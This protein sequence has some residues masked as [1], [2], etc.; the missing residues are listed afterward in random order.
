MSCVPGCLCFNDVGVDLEQP[1][2]VCVCGH[3]LAVHKPAALFCM[4]TYACT[5]RVGRYEGFAFKNDRCKDP[6]CGHPRSRHHDKLPAA[7]AGVA[8]SINAEAIQTALARIMVQDEQ[9]DEEDEE[10]AT[11]T[12]SLEAKEKE[13]DLRLDSALD[14]AVSKAIAEHPHAFE[15]MMQGCTAMLAEEGVKTV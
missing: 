11:A 10:A 15:H 5:C 4:A 14:G 13:E 6:A 1:D 2:A 12:T 3:K 9:E 7:L 8:H